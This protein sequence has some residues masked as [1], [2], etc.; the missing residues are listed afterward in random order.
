M[1]DYL[2]SVLDVTAPGY[3]YNAINYLFK[4]RQLG[5]SHFFVFSDDIA[6][7]KEMLAVLPYQFTFADINDNA[8][9]AY[10]M[11]LMSQCH[12][13]I[14]SNSTFGFWPALLSERTDEKIVIQPSKW[15]K[16]DTERTEP[17]YP[18]WI[19]MDC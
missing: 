17:R 13:F 6:K 5:K 9:G 14:I 7:S 10:D 15:L 16:T 2:G 8:H 1:G 4:E 3:F 12:H 18:G 19:S 11:Y